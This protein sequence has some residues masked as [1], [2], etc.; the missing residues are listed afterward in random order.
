MSNCLLQGKPRRIWIPWTRKNQQDCQWCLRVVGQG[1]INRF[2]FNWCWRT[3]SHKGIQTTHRTKVMKQLGFLASTKQK[4]WHNFLLVQECNPQGISMAE[5]CQILREVLG[6]K[7]LWQRCA[8]S[9]IYVLIFGG[10]DPMYTHT[11]NA[12][13]NKFDT[14][15]D[16][17]LR[18]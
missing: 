12:L 6:R 10:R 16:I 13:N 3:R 11:I 1:K 9:N 2:G 4:W 15:P 5:G 14:L 7:H 18:N 8:F 17:D